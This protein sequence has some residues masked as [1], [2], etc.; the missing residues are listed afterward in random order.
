MSYFLRKKNEEIIKDCQNF[1]VALEVSPRLNVH[2]LF[3]ARS[4]M[5][6][7]C[8]YRLEPLLANLGE[9]WIYRNEFE[10]SKR[11]VWVENIADSVCSLF[12]LKNSRCI[13]IRFAMQ[14]L[15]LRAFRKDNIYFRTIEDLGEN[16][17]RKL[18]FY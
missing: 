1:R 15:T 4:S 9:R 8:A 18:N 3:E 13:V 17:G 10:W 2:S 12:S 11:R 14:D 5:S 7:S 16:K 6:E